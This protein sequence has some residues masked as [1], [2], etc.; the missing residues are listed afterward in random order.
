MTHLGADGTAIPDA[1][2][3]RT[4]PTTEPAEGEYVSAFASTLHA[5]GAWQD[6]EQH[7]S[8]AGGLL[9]HEIERNHPRADVVISRLSFDILG[10]IHGGDFTV[11]TRV[12]R[13]GRT[14]ELVEATMAHGDRVAIR[15]LVWRLVTTDT[16]EVQGNWFAPIEGPDAGTRRLLTKDWSGGFIASLEA[17]ELRSPEPGRNTMWMRTRT[18]LVDGEPEAGHEAIAGTVGLMDTAN[19]VATRV[20]PREWLFPNVDLS[21]HLFRTP[22]AGWL[23]FDTRVAFGPHGQGLTTTVL[24][25]ER[26]AVGTVSQSLTVRAMPP[27]RQQ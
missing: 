21:V 18:P 10:V 15:A 2:Y 19:G 27:E 9:V 22:V 7:M 20:D 23:G 5:Q 6:H 11:T 4:G 12:S 17:R 25:D 1:Y 16:S 26:G 3:V 8:P 24:H 13:P 14:I